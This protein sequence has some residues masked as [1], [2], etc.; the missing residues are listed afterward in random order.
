MNKPNDWDSVQA[1]GDF[2]A[3]ELGG[4]V[5][6]ILKAESTV[7]K[8]GRPALKL[9]LDI[10]DGKQAGYFKKSFDN[11]TFADK[12]WPNGGQFTQITDGTS[13]KFFKGVITAIEKSNTG[14]KWAWDETTLKGKLIGGVFGREQ[15]E[16]NGELK[17]ATKCVQ[18]KSTEGIVDV[19]APADKLLK[20]SSDP[21][22][23]YAPAPS[24]DQ[25]ADLD[26]SDGD[27]PL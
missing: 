23:V 15:Y 20:S 1:A 14:Y 3:L 6:K 10:A 4:H 5:C 22:A 7:T 21:F 27:L 2:E 8:S 26:D 24:Y 9:F 11:S 19:P 12:K 13:T 18:V 16:K 17:Y 25:F